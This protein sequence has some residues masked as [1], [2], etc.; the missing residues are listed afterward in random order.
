MPRISARIGDF[1]TLTVHPNGAVIDYFAQFQRVNG[2]TVEE[3]RWERATIEA[4]HAFTFLRG[5]VPGYNLVLYPK[6]R[7]GA[8]LDAIVKVEA[9]EHQA[10]IRDSRPFSWSIILE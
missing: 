5:N 7:E 6:L 8:W 3:L 4:G 10:A 2:S 1:L 9:N